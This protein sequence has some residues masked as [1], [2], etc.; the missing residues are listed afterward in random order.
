MRNKCSTWNQKE[1]QYIF[2]FHRL[3]WPVRT[4][5]FSHNGDLLA[6]ASEDHVIDISNVSM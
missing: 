4:L 2:C 5:S 1:N 3:D 6:A